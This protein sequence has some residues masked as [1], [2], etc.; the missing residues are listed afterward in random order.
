MRI[1]ATDKDVVSNELIDGLEITAYRGFHRAAILRY[2]IALNT[3]KN[4]STK[5]RAQHHLA[6]AGSIRQ[7]AQEIVTAREAQ[8]RYPTDR[9]ARKRWDHTA[10]HFGYLYPASQL[11]FWNRE[12][13]QAKRN[14]YSAFFMNIWN[15]GR[16]VGLIK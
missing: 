3:A 4:K 1:N 13:Q 16:I 15:V 5:T 11:H 2:L 6:D 8:Y 14:R 7:R 12:E 9:I 10:Y